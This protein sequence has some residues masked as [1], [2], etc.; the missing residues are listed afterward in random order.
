M[1]Y[2]P[3]PEHVLPARQSLGGSDREGPPDHL[4][5]SYNQPMEFFEAERYAL[6]GLK[7]LKE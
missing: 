5:L 7:G 6:M 3:V 4:I 2:L 1:L